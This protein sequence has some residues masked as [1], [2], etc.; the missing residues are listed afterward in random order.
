MRIW[1]MSGSYLDPYAVLVWFSFG[2]FLDLS[3][4]NGRIGLSL[5]YL[6]G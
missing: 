3:G 1:F 5:V 6:A 4:R 2:F